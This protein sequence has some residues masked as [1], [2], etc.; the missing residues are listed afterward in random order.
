MSKANST[1]SFDAQ[2]VLKR[3]RGKRTVH[4]MTT[5][6]QPVRRKLQPSISRIS[7]STAKI[8]YIRLRRKQAEAINFEEVF[9]FWT[10]EGVIT[11][12]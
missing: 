8:S 10:R 7:T 3:I 5:P 4:E 6:S 11:V 9:Q 2:V 12:R 1:E